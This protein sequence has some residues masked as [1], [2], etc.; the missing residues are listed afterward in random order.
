[1]KTISELNQKIWYRFLKVVY[2]LLLFIGAIYVLKLSKLNLQD[3]L[4]MSFFLLCLFILI[5]RTF[6]YVALGAFSPKK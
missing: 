2:C 3:F 1:M 4:L 6:Y 5:Q